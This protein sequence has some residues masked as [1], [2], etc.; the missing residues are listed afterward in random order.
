MKRI[1]AITLILVLCFSLCACGNANSAEATEPVNTAS[2]EESTA[3]TAAQTAV[4]EKPAIWSLQQTVDEF[5]DVT[6]NSETIIVAPFKGTFSNT[7]TTSSELN[8]TMVIQK[9]P[10][11]IH[12]YAAFILYEYGDNPAD[13]SSYDSKTLKVKIGDVISQFPLQS[14]SGN[15]GLGLGIDTF[16]YGGDWLLGQLY[17]GQDL[18]CI[19]NVGTSQYNFT[20]ESANLPQ[21][22][23][24]N[25]FAIGPA[26]LTAKEAI[27]IYLTDD[28][29]V[30]REAQDFFIRHINDY[31]ILNSTELSQLLIGNFLEIQVDTFSPYWTIQKYENGASAQIAFLADSHG[32]R[33]FEDTTQFVAQPFSTS[34]DLLTTGAGKSIE[35]AFQVRKI[36]D[37]I[38][39]R[40]KAD[41]NGHY[42]VPDHFMISYN[43]PVTGF[44][45]VG[46]MINYIQ[47][48]MLPQIEEHYMYFVPKG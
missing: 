7:A 36:A 44:S 35:K 38:Y 48:S 23:V 20:V 25:G 3:I 12:Y 15:P 43:D 41:S 9:R 11:N 14:V 40:Y 29:H 17:M 45:S 19:I 31:E 21:L 42:S 37:G 33:S 1:V 22:I 28:V 47:T 27:N 16:D 4:Q 6:A 39:I 5:G 30:M 34:N 18:R 32:T 46:T 2:A 10:D 8:V 26:E 13:Y 24:E